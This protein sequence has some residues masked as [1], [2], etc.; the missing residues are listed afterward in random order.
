VWMWFPEVGYLIGFL[1]FNQKASTPVL[2]AKQSPAAESVSWTSNPNDPR[3]WHTTTVKVNWGERSNTHIKGEA[4][5]TPTLPPS[6]TRPSKPSILQSQY[7]LTIPLNCLT[8]L[9]QEYIISHNFHSAP[10]YSSK[11]KVSWA[12]LL[13][14]SSGE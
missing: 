7:V 1:E 12:C 13:K 14:E 9:H 5:R 4:P 8:H 11:S 3:M 2:E 6:P 10:A